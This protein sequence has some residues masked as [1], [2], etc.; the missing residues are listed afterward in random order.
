MLTLRTYPFDGD[1]SSG[2]FVYTKDAVEVVT[3]YIRSRASLVSPSGQL[4]TS[5]DNDIIKLVLNNLLSDVDDAE[6][7]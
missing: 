2:D 4:Y 3:K 1:T 7:S 6:I 5:A